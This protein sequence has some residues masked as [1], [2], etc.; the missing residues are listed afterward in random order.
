M[1][2]VRLLLILL[3]GTWSTQFCAQESVLHTE[4]PGTLA[5]TS[6]IC[7][8]G[9]TTVSKIQEWSYRNGSWLPSRLNPS[10]VRE[11]YGHSLS[12]FRI[13]LEPHRLPR[14]KRGVV[15]HVVARE[16]P[17]GTSVNFPST[18]NV[19][20]DR[21]RIS[22]RR[23]AG[24]HVYQAER[25]ER[26]LMLSVTADQQPYWSYCYRLYFAVSERPF[27]TACKVRY[28]YLEVDGDTASLYEYA[29]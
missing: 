25:F 17:G 23:Y 6:V 10:R 16:N 19:L 4:L 18:G 5:S 9:T 28:F 2:R 1:L 24:H 22:R 27:D 29:C 7:P 12:A 3:L 8:I 11:R 13:Y 21:S 15:I 14:Q 20:L 26:K